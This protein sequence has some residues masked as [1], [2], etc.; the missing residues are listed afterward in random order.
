MH[1]WFFI[2]PQTTKTIIST[3][4][5]CRKGW[6][7]RFG[8]S[9]STSLMICVGFKTLFYKPAFH[10]LIDQ[11]ML[12]EH[13]WTWTKLWIF[14]VIQHLTQNKNMNRT[15]V[16]SNFSPLFSDVET[17]RIN[18]SLPFVVWHYKVQFHKKLNTGVLRMHISYWYDIYFLFAEKNLSGHEMFMDENDKMILFYYLNFVRRK[19][20]KKL[21]ISRVFSCQ[22]FMYL[23]RLHT[24]KSLQCRVRNHFSKVQWKVMN[25]QY[26]EISARWWPSLN[27]MQ[28]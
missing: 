12:S 10:E 18:P 2:C 3:Y 21:W 1:P 9:I 5:G 28:K 15:K 25:R 19:K 11:K 16:P 13:I 8:H 7:G 22:F 27:L 24:P 14:I 20:I 17:S 26:N 4:P 23:G 6:V